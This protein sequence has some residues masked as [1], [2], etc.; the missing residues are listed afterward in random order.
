MRNELRLQL[1]KD[2][3]VIRSRSFL[4]KAALVNFVLPVTIRLRQRVPGRKR[5][6]RVVPV[7]ARSPAP[8]STSAANPTAQVDLGPS[9]GQRTIALGGSLAA[10]VQFSDTYDGGA[11]GNVNIKLLPSTKKF[12]STS[13]VPILWN[14]DATDPGTRSDANWIA[15][16]TQAGG[17]LSPT[18]SGLRAGLRRL[19]HQPAGQHAGRAA[20]RGPDYSA[21]MYGFQPSPPIAPYGPGEGLPGYPY[22]DPAGPGGTTT[23]AG[24]LP[25]YPG[26]D[27]LDR[28]H[29]EQR[30]RQQRRAR[31]GQKPFPYPAIAPGGF[32]QPP[33][34]RST[35]FRTNA[36][37]LAI[38]APGI[39]V[40]QS[41]GTSVNGQPLLSNGPQGSQNIIIGTPAARRTCSG[42]SPAR[43]TASTSR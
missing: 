6:E 1:R 39:Q 37:Q 35:V 4:R 22:Y 34:V 28:A 30:R 10:E 13:S 19:P 21:L 24:Y 16:T 11:L 20:G 8:R 25:V 23:P 27:A 9:L 17:V 14:P 36:L 31:P 38:A 5:R 7:R 32:T 12:I 41:T 18:P 40:D 26:V 29:V 42:T 2:P 43:A 33:D 3:S 15:A